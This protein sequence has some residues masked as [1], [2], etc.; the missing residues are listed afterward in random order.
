MTNHKADWDY[1]QNPNT[2]RARARTARLSEYE[3]KRENA[4][5]NDQ[6]AIKRVQNVESNKQS[7]RDASE[8]EQALILERAKDTI[9]TTRR[10]KGIDFASTMRRFEESQNQQQS[11]SPT[12]APSPSPNQGQSLGSPGAEDAP[13]APFGYAA[14][15]NSTPVPGN[16][17][18]AGPVR[19]GGP[20]GPISSVSPIGPY[21]HSS[22]NP[23]ASARGGYQGYQVIQFPPPKAR[24]KVDANL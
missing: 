8:A 18:F 6:K 7:F 22:R 24:I 4:K 21:P 11:Q 12:E 20:V 15:N 1:S 19:P 13:F 14:M 10:E 5:A 3:R 9:M 23:S 2:V 16:G 17:S